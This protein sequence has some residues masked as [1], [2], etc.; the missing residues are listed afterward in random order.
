MAHQLAEATKDEV[1]RAYAELQEKML[2]QAIW[3][4]TVDSA[5]FKK[6]FS[7]VSQIIIDSLK[8]MN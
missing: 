6:A 1:I 2:Q 8:E 5:E 4:G 7:N 3:N